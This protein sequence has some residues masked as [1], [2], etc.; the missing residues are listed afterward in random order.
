M[1]LFVHLFV[2]F[3]F[4][5][6]SLER[7]SHFAQARN[8]PASGRACKQFCFPHPANN[9]KR[10]GTASYIARFANELLN[11][12]FCCYFTSSC[13][14]KCSNGRYKDAYL[15]RLARSQKVTNHGF[16]SKVCCANITMR[17]LRLIIEYYLTI[18]VSS[19]VLI[20]L[21]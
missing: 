8:S 1:F 20:V 12:L 10:N 17:F 2:S 14:R 6:R 19:S 4:L 5:L 21:S 13:R 7:H 15:S 18:R 16:N 3:V 9:N 11:F